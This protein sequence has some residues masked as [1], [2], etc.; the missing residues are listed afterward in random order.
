MYLC[1]ENDN[2]KT[3]TEYDVIINNIKKKQKTKYKTF[4]LLLQDFSKDYADTQANSSMEEMNNE[5][6]VD[7]DS[8]TTPLYE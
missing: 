5:Q 3:L 2:I 4:L 7:S 1:S 6:K 8:K